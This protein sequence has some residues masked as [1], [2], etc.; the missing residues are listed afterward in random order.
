[1]LG[2]Q[3]WRGLGNRDWS[4]VTHR[5]LLRLTG[6]TLLWLTGSGLLD[7]LFVLFLHPANVVTLCIEVTRTIHNVVE[8]GPDRYIGLSFL[9]V[10]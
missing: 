9:H 5:I 7:T 4:W 6:C 8:L 1:M 2:L 3:S 10:D